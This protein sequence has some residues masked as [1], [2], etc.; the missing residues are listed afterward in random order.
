MAPSAVALHEAGHP[1]SCPGEPGVLP[2]GDV[3]GKEVAM[4]VGSD[5]HHSSQLMRALL[6]CSGP[7]HRP[8]RACP[9]LHKV[10]ESAQV[11]CCPMLFK[12]KYSTSPQPTFVMQNAAEEDAELGKA[13]MSACRTRGGQQGATGILKH[14]SSHHHFLAQ[15][16]HHSHSTCHV[17]C[18]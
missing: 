10:S 5:A 18:F 16:R 2:F 7:G 1:K 17:Q 8:W 14:P 15:R 4:V 11:C 6:P 9:P 3:P 13:D 12:C